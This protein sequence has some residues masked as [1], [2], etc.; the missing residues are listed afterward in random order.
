[1]VVPVRTA[2]KTIK[3]LVFSS[4]LL[5]KSIVLAS[6]DVFSRRE[7]TTELYLQ[8]LGESVWGLSSV[9]DDG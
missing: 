8:R 3:K 4:E 1:M 6:G 2:A 7:P 5:R 9:N